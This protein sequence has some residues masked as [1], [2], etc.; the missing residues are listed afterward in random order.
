MGTVPFTDEET[1]AWRGRD[2]PRKAQVASGQWRP[3]TSMLPPCI[4]R[5]SL[6]L[7]S[8]NREQ[9]LANPLKDF[10]FTL[11]LSVTITFGLGEIAKVYSSVLL[12]SRQSVLVP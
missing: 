4:L 10:V 7:V 1:E 12:V 9:M 6:G 8:I 11:L 3:M 2:F 5:S